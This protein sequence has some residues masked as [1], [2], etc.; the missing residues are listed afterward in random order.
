MTRPACAK[1]H[2]TLILPCPQA[3]KRVRRTFR[4]PP[5][6]ISSTA[7]PATS[8]STASASDAHCA[9]AGRAGGGGLGLVALEAA[10]GAHTAPAAARCL[11]EHRANSNGKWAYA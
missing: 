3:R 8:A 6:S 1:H 10:T 9:S 5:T 11:S 4:W 2:P 7:L